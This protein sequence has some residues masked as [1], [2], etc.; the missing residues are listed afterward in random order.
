MDLNTLLEYLSRS[1]DMLLNLHDVSGI[2]SDR[3]FGVDQKFKM[4]ALGF[5][6]AAKTT[7]MGY[8][9]CV[10]CKKT[11]CRIAIRR[12]RGFFGMCPY[13]INELVYPI[14]VGGKVTCIL[15]IGNTTDNMEETC[16]R[17]RIMCQK[18]GVDY[19][20][21]SKHFSSVRKTDKKL[22]T[23]TAQIVADHIKYKFLTEKRNIVFSRG[24]GIV[25]QLCRHAEL[26]Y[27]R[28]LTLKA[29]SDMY[30]INEKYAGRLFTSQMGCTF[31]EYLTD[32]RL[33][34]A[35]AHLKNSE[36]NITEIAIACGF[37]TISYFN[38]AFYKRNNMS[39]SEYRKVFKTK[40][41]PRIYG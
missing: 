21:L 17:A 34:A 4:H 1:C 8:D 2:L 29:L 12:K 15:F 11:V 10:R 24:D 5:C 22:M 30:F 33:E 18:T 23:E 35:E 28:S 32:R 26:N 37:N 6:D 27:S 9:R 7:P 25:S 41:M 20:E 3:V 39:P 36:L 13:G 14:S 31:H 38:R 40:S 16:R 19:A